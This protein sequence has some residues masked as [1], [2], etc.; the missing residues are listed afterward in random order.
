MSKRDTLSAV[1]ERMISLRMDDESEAALRALTAGGRS[2]SDVIREALVAAAR[3][4]SDLAAEARMVRED[5]EDRA[6]MARVR[7]L[8][9][10]LRDPW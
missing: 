3:R 8:M 4:R 2:R 7:E 9:E 6:E 1:A 10:S 5:P